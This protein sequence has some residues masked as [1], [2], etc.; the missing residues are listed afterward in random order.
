MQRVTIV[1]VLLIILI[2]CKKDPQPGNPKNEQVATTFVQTNNIDFK[3]SNVVGSAPL[4]LTTQAYINQNLDT[5]TVDLF[6]YYISNIKL[7]RDDGFEFVEPESYRLIDQ[8]DSASWNFT[9]KNVPLG[10]Y[11][12]MEFIIGVDSARNCSGAQSGALDP[13]HDM[14]WDWSQGYIFAKLQGSCHSAPYN[15]YFN[16]IGG[17]TGQWSAIVKSTPSFGTNVIQVSTDRVPKVFMKADV[18]EWFK[19]PQTIDIA[20][21]SAV[22]TGKKGHEIAT[23][24]ADMFSVTAIT[25]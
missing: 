9:L 13:I 11:V 6:K 10:N 2:S 7:K 1:I 17:F 3:L 20:S 14:F 19:N 24:Y 16:H 15:T 12:S 22:T 21:Y 23:N 25:N 5:F 18:L 8:N 4:T